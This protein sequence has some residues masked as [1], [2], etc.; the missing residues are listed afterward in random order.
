MYLDGQHVVLGNFQSLWTDVDGGLFL[1][2]G[3][4]ACCRLGRLSGHILLN[5][6]HSR[7]LSTVLVKTRVVNPCGSVDKA[8][9]SDTSAIGGFPHQ[10]QHLLVLCFLLGIACDVNVQLRDEHRHLQGVLL[11]L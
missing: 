10:W 4:W 1:G 5:P 6:G 11:F 2:A 8:P 3:E 9:Q 7:T